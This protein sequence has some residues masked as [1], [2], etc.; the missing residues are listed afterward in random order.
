LEDSFIRT[1]STWFQNG[2]G[3]EVTDFFEELGLAGRLLFS[4]KGASFLSLVE[5]GIWQDGVFQRP[6]RVVP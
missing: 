4:A 3:P 5:A 6:R 1:A 2:I